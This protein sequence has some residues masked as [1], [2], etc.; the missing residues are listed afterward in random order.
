MSRK[1]QIVLVAAVAAAALPAAAHA[2][3]ISGVVV[4]KDATR[5][6]FVVSGS[7]G[8]AVTVS[9]PR[10]HPR[11]G[12]RLVVDGRRLANG[13]VG[14]RALRVVG[15]TRRAV[16]R[17]VV[18]K[19]LAGRTIVST[20]RAVLTI[21]RHSGVRTLSMV[22][23]HSGLRTGTVARF[24]VAVT[25]AGL[26]QTSV[27]TLGV[28]STV[29]VEGELVSV[30]PLVVN[31]EGLPVTIGVPSGASLPAGLTPGGRVEL[32]VTVGEDNSVTLKSFDEVSG[33]DEQGDDNDQGEDQQVGSDDAEPGAVD[34][35]PGDVAD[36]PNDDHGT[37]SGHNS[38]PGSD[39]SGDD[40]SSSGGG[41]D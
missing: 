5:G 25:S 29:R 18:V 1:R 31:V 7:S 17:G 37:T 30:S 41:D 21:R 3:R 39:D 6:S 26:T 40:S 19:Q 8:A 32:T 9:A 4:A 36:D 14:V 33:Q 35:D 12:D 34:D 20:G 27:T 24:D 2:A 13:T 10:A 22:D 16:V 15:H 11:L 38:G 28:T 23:G